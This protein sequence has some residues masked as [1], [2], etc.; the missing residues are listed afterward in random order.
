MLAKLL[1][2]LSGQ[3]AGR[4]Q[5][6]DGGPHYISLHVG[7]FSPCPRRP[8]LFR[9]P[10]SFK[11]TFGLMSPLSANDPQRD[12]PLYHSLSLSLLV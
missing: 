4:L 7:P 1:G 5:Y 6:R 11:A 9:E 8:C 3:P 12:P 2:N 10:E